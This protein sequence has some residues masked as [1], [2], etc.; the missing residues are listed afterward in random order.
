MNQSY[1]YRT[2]PHASE[3]DGPLYTVGYFEPDGAWCPV[4]DHS[5]EEEATERVHYLNGG[6][7]LAKVKAILAST[8]TELRGADLLIARL[9]DQISTMESALKDTRVSEE[10][11]F[12]AEFLRALNISKDAKIKE[13]TEQL[14]DAGAR[15]EQ[16]LENRYA[17]ELRQTG[18]CP[19]CGAEG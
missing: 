4:S 7:Q 14:Q 3:D 17:K 1:V 11:G 9:R 12:S 19:F 16:A 10:K 18:R 8:E 6:E 13:L 2:T 15:A 5:Q